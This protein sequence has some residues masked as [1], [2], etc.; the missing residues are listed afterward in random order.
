MSAT[1][2]AVVAWALDTRSVADKVEVTIRATIFFIL[3]L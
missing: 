1:V 3:L 2:R